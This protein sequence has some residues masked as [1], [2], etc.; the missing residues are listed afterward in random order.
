MRT[1]MALLIANEGRPTMTYK[2][3]AKL[4]DKAP[5]TVLNEISARRA[6]VPMWKD[7]DNWVCNVSDVA[8][9]LDRER[10]AAIA[11]DPRLQDDFEPSQH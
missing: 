11:A 9:W 4:R 10:D 2:E 7:G 3:F 5:R 8:A 6:P 1:L